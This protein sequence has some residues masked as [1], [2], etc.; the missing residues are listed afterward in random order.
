MAK[1]PS[2]VAQF[3]SKGGP[4]PELEIDQILVLAEKHPEGSVW[5][6]TKLGGHL[7]LMPASRCV[8]FCKKRKGY[9]AFKAKVLKKESSMPHEKELVDLYEGH[10]FSCWWNVTDLERLDFENLE[11]LPGRHIE[12]GKNARQSFAGTCTF[13]YWDFEDQIDTFERKP[14]IVDEPNL[15]IETL[16]HLPQKTTCSEFKSKFNGTLDLYGVDFS[17]GAETDRGNSKLWIAHLCQKTGV[18]ELLRGS[19][20][21]FRRRDLSKKIEKSNGIWILDF[22]F[23]IS[24]GIMRSSNINE[25][26]TWIEMCG[27]MH[28]EGKSMTDLRDQLRDKA[29]GSGTTWSTP[30][31]VDTENGTTWFPL[32]EQLYRQTISG[33]AEVLFPILGSKRAAIL[34]WNDCTANQAIVSEGFPGAVLRSDLNMSPTGYKGRQANRIDKRKSIVRILSEEF[35]LPLTNEQKKV[36]VD[37]YEG[38]AIDAVL[39]LLSAKK[40][41]NPEVRQEIRAKANDPNAVV[42]GWFKP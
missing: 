42:E 32:F 29:L 21:S 9:A 20:N 28:N 40:L 41:E 4:H 18:L 13:A 31:L 36:L 10:S 14:I 6:P 12:S 27:N 15:M 39:L 3:T 22:P 19:E 23:G 2:F 17:G 11:Q 7:D 34:P 25:W 1:K 16:P 30:R 26:T 24:H 37:D 35:S 38:D 8:V 33:A 5:F